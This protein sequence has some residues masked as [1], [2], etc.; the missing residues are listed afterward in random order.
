[1]GRGGIEC[2]IRGRERAAAGLASE[3]LLRKRHELLGE[4]VDTGGDR[5]A[6]RVSAWLSDL[7]DGASDLNAQYL[8]VVGA[9]IFPIDDGRCGDGRLHVGM[10]NRARYVAC[11]DRAH[12]VDQNLLA[13]ERGWT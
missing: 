3:R 1:M 6:S 10:R 8:A 11:A 5:L 12:T 7:D 13:E 2:S 9:R 4:G